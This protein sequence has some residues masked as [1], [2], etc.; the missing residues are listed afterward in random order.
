[1]TNCLAYT[2]NSTWDSAWVSGWKRVAGAHVLHAMHRLTRILC[3]HWSQVWCKRI[4][5]MVS[6]VVVNMA[7]TRDLG[8]KGDKLMS[9]LDWLK[10][11]DWMRGWM[12]SCAFIFCDIFCLYCN[13]CLNPTQFLQY[14]NK[15]DKLEVENTNHNAISAAH[16][17]QRF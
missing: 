4:A 2:N 15:W 6:A 17:E 13:D 7:S 5:R 10:T 3:K 11:R 16:L 8:V 1:M 14:L 12:T 9:C